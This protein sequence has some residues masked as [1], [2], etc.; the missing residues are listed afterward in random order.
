[1]SAQRILRNP[2]AAR[3]L[4][5]AP[6]TLAKMRSRGEGPAFLRLGARLVGYDRGDLDQWL[7]GRRA[8]DHEESGTDAEPEQDEG[9]AGR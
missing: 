1:M 7:D 2:A 4:G 8:L 9:T 6:A 3:Y 5:I